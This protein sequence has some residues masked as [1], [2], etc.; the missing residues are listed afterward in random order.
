MVT[1]INN[2]R[3]EN[4][5]LQRR[6]R[7]FEFDLNCLKK[8]LEYKDVRL[9]ELSESHLLENEKLKKDIESKDV[10]LQRWI[11]NCWKMENISL[12]MKMV[13]SIGKHQKESM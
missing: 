5:F 8:D 12:C 10:R 13:S 9:Q 1:E 11:H 6:I 4:V 7:E 3:E 2:Y